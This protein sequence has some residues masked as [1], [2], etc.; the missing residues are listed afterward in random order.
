MWDVG[1]PDASV[2]GSGPEPSVDVDRLKVGSV[3]TLALEVAF[4]ARGINGADV[5][6]LHNFG[7]QFK[8][9]GSVEAYE[10][11]AP[12]PAK[13]SSVEP[14]PVLEFVPRLPPREEVVMAFPFHV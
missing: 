1:G 8:L 9:S 13:V 7:E 11:H 5:I 2:A 3:A 14:I 6:F 12:V 10:I 4:T